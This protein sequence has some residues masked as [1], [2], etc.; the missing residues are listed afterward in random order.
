[1]QQ[2]QNGD[3]K[4]PDYGTLTP[5]QWHCNNEG[6]GNNNNLTNKN[7]KTTSTNDNN[8]G[9]DWAKTAPSNFNDHKHDN[10]YYHFSNYFYLL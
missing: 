5:K 8:S 7:N 6:Q 2:W 10:E 9:Q 4:P 1:M 3:G